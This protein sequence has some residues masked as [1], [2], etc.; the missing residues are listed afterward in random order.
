MARGL[1]LSIDPASGSIVANSRR[2]SR[3][4]ISRGTGYTK[5]HISRIFSG[6]RRPSLNSANR[7]AGFLGVT[8]EVFSQFSD[9]LCDARI[10]DGKD[11]D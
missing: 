2:F 9:L 7:I 4:D 3:G 8:V 10:E 1:P 5:I 11:E 6:Q